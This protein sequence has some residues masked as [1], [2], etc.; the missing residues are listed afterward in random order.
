MKIYADEYAEVS[1]PTTLEQ[2]KALSRVTYPTEM[3]LIEAFN[4]FVLGETE[5]PEWLPADCKIELK[6]INCPN[7]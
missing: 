6:P 7:D 2:L 3:E 4:A 5:R 1:E